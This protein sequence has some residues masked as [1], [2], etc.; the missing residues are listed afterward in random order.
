MMKKIIIFIFII[1]AILSTGLYIYLNYLSNYNIAQKENIKFEI[2]KDE[3][4]DGSKLTTLINKAID[5]NM[6]NEVKKDNKGKYV[7]NGENSINIDVKFIDN[8]SVFNIEK[9]YNGGMATFLSYY[10]DIIFKCNDV[11]YHEK[12]GKVKYMLFEQVTQ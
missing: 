1:I 9:I 7:D 4:I 8:D 6:R 5:L 3:N 11:Q 10:G 12:T 2:Y